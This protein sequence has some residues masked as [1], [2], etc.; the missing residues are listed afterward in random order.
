MPIRRIISFSLIFVSSY[1]SIIYLMNITK[2]IYVSQIDLRIF[3]A[4]LSLLAAFSLSYLFFNNNPNKKELIIKKEYLFSFNLLLIIFVIGA[5]YLR[6]DAFSTYGSMV[7]QRWEKISF[8]DLVLSIMFYCFLLYFPACILHKTLLK[9]F[10]LDSLGKIVFYPMVSMLIFGFASFMLPPL[11]DASY[12]K[13]LLPVALPSFLLIYGIRRREWEPIKVT[14]LN[15]TEILGLTLVISL[16][17]FL[18]YSAIG[19]TNAFVRGDAAGQVMNVGSINKLGLSAYLDRPL[20]AG[21]SI[22]HIAG[23]SVLTRLLPLPYCNVLIIVQFFNH[24]FITLAFY[25]LAKILL[26]NV[27]ESLLATVFLTVLS[28]F[29]WFYLVTNPPPSFLSGT[30]FRGYIWEVFN[31]FG[32]ES[33]AKTSMIYADDHAL[34]RLWPL[35]VCLAS[36]AALLNIRYATNSKRGYLLIFSIGFLQ[37]ALGHSYELILLGLSLFAFSILTSKNLDKE[38][39]FAVG[40][41]TMLS[42]FLAWVLGYSTDFLKLA[43]LPSI[44]LIL[45]ILLT[46]IVNSEKVKKGW[47]YILTRKRIVLSVLSVIFI[48]CYGLSWIAFLSAYYQIQIGVPI[49]TLWYSPPIQW[50]FLG[51][52]F[53]MVMIKGALTKWR[54]PVFYLKFIMMMLTSLLILTVFLDCVN[55]YFFYLG[56]PP[57]MPHYFLPFFALG[58]VYIFKPVN[59]SSKKIANVKNILII[60]LL[61]LILLLGSLTHILSASYWK[62]SGWSREDSPLTTLSDEEIEF[63]DFLY[64]H[65]YSGHFEMAGFLPSDQPIPPLDEVS[66]QNKVRY[67]IYDVDYLIMLSG[68]GIPQKLVPSVLYDAQGLNEIIFLM[69]IYP[70]KYLV[71]DRNATSFLAQYMRENEPPIFKGKY[72]VYDLSNLQPMK[73]NNLKIQEVIL[74]DEVLFTGNLTFMDEK[75]QKKILNGVSGAL[76]PL[77]NGYTQIKIYTGYREESKP[78]LTDGESDNNETCVYDDDETLWHSYGL[79]SGNLTAPTLSE[80]ITQKVESSSSLKVEISTGGKYEVPIVYVP[81]YSYSKPRPDWSGKDFISIYLYGL[82]DGGRITVAV[83]GGGGSGSNARLW[84]INDNF[85]GWKRCVLPVNNPS[86]D[87]GSFNIS[88]INEVHV[89]WNTAGTRYVDRMIVDVSP[90]I[91]VKPKNVEAEGEVTL[92]NMRSTS[93]Y[94]PEA[95]HLAQK[96]VIQGKV[97]F[98]LLNTFDNKR[99]YIGSFEYVGCE[100]IHPEPWHMTA[101]VAKQALQDYIKWANIPFLNVLKGTCG[102]MWTVLCSIFVVFTF[103]GRVK[104][105]LRWKYSEKK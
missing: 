55:L 31:K 3:S 4:I 91:V 84:F 8:I 29:S 46:R 42:A 6:F 11:Q 96:V 39:L 18:Q 103:S 57:F 97:S 5:Y 15:L 81:Y 78:D 49:F 54:N 40:A 104:I 7:F 79:G 58:S 41:S 69:Q 9:G 77:E 35:G 23:W 59:V 102:L 61:L 82:N 32:T 98:N 75:S 43:F 51:F 85:S 27:R 72:I 1:L 73:E 25:L 21:Y 44:A 71:V 47:N 53:A 60:T 62:T 89:R 74:V 50:G 94:F 10:K 66:Y 17:L 37:I 45:A 64:N 16:R 100:Q 90:R 87:G 101:R 20:T 65:S 105:S 63:V 30:E 48:W 13:F 19:E 2:I 88:S 52:L 83:Y 99:L 36:I 24:V 33:G 67:P 34:N 38:F 86:W 70:L 80:E 26:K 95:R 28:G 12:L 93:K 92:V 14:I 22:S 76:S 56:S 68:I